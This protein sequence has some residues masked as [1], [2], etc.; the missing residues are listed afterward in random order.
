VKE[1]GLNR[2]SS[3]HDMNRLSPEYKW[4]IYTWKL[5]RQRRSSK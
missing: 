4:S 3:T 5:A 2:E 1:K